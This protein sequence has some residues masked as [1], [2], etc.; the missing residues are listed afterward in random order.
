MVRFAR[1]I[2]RRSMAWTLQFWGAAAVAIPELP[3]P[4]ARL[5]SRHGFVRVV[6]MNLNAFDPIGS[7]ACNQRG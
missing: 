6:A 2:E 4:V 5:R 1:S 3:L 7:R